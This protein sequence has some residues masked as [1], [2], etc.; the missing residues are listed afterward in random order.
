VGIIAGAIVIVLGGMIWL[1]SSLGRP[2]GQL[3]DR[4]PEPTIAIP[5]GTQ[6]TGGEADPA[7]EPQVVTGLPDTETVTM[8]LFVVDT[9]AR[10]LVPRIRRVE[11]PMTLPA[12]AQLALEMLVRARNA[13]GPLPSGTVIR[14]LWVSPGGVAFVDF[15]KTF[16]PRLGGGSLAEIHAVFGVVATLTSSFPNIRSVQFLVD[17]EPVDS[18]TGHVD[19]S[20]PIRPLADWVY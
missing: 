5:G 18:L 10:R 16:P 17:G 6:P 11:A 4:G 2:A 3:P 1:V 8:Q 13:G 15:D 7:G 14:E 12:Q 19:L 9:A 20:G